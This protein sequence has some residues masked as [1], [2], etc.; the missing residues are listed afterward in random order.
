MGECA[1]LIAALLLGAALGALLT[2]PIL[3]Y[4]AALVA[5]LA[6]RKAR[7]LRSLKEAVE[8][9]GLLVVSWTVVATLLHYS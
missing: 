7:L 2:P 8:Y 9:V 6:L 3:G 4:L 5:G 1:H